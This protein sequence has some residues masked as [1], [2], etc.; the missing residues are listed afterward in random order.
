M[1]YPFTHG[2][3]L[4][5]LWEARFKK[6]KFYDFKIIFHLSYESFFS[7]MVKK[8]NL[9][10]KLDKKQIPY[11]TNEEFLNLAVKLSKNPNYLKT[12]DFWGLHNKVLN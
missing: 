8:K 9:F 3:R 7:G 4:S 5:S 10:E 1:N 12:D 2:I 11:L 6:Y